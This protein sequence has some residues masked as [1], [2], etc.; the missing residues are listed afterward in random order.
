MTSIAWALMGTGWFADDACAG[1]IKRARGARLL[2]ALGSSQEK[3]REFAAR[4]GLAKSYGSIDELA[5]DGEVDAVWI[6]TPNNLHVVHATRLA[7]AGKHVLVEKP[8][9]TTFADAQGLEWAARQSGRIVRV[10]YHHRFRPIHSEMR[11]RILAGR[12]GGVC[13]YR[14]HFFVNI[15]GLPSAWRRRSV[16]SGGWAINDVGTHLIDLMLWMTNLPAAVVGARL[17]PQLRG[18]ETDDGA[19]VLFSLGQSATGVVETSMALTSPASRIEVYG[20]AGWLRAEGSLGG[21]TLLETSEA[22]V[23]NCGG[24]D[25]DPF[26]AEV[27]A[28]QDAIEGRTSEIGDLPRAVENV[29]LIQEARLLSE[30]R[31]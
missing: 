22:G 23:V 19:T 29:K 24:G 15:G 17:V 30:R 31:Q 21:A 12:I 2:G 27:E 16:S 20:E 8:L 28:F 5:A 11:N 3:S 26:V 25:H 6:T 7:K 1:A 14:I 10:G 4:H 13:L 9:A 18:L